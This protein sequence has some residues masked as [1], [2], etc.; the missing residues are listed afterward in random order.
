MQVASIAAIAFLWLGPE[1]VWF[2]SVIHPDGSVSP[3]CA[4]WPQNT[5]QFPLLY[6]QGNSGNRGAI[7]EYT[8]QILDL[9]VVVTHWPYLLSKVQQS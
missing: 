1:A 4:I 7:L 6:R 9:N 5:E 8:I 3:C 2:E